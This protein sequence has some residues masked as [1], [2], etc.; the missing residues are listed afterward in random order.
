MPFYVFGQQAKNRHPLPIAKYNENVKLPLTANERAQI[1][2]VYGES[3]DEYV[4]S[5]PHRLKTIKHI[6]RNRVVVKMISDENSK[7]ACDKLSEVSVF[8]GF[9]PDLKRDQT[10]NPNSFNP[11]K[12]NFEF[13]SRSAAM[14]QVDNTNYYIIIKSQYQ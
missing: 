12:Y 4:F 2:E 14:Y 9:V 13:Y 5:N 10:F 11:L 7:K 6:L 1:I 8:N 3:A